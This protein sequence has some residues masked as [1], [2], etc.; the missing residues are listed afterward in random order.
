MKSCR[1]E[2]LPGRPKAML[3]EQ[4]V[5]FCLS[6]D[7]MLLGIRKHMRRKWFGALD[8]CFIPFPQ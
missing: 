1:K 2:S 4:S 7:G 5:I 8:R 6:A 3:P